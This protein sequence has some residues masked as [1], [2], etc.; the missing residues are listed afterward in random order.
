MEKKCFKGFLAFLLLAVVLSFSNVLYAQQKTIQGKITDAGNTPL[1][2]VSVS[3]KGTT[4]GTVT[5]VDGI[6]ELIVPADAANLLYSYI[7]M[8]T[9][10]I[11]I[12]TQTTINVVLQEDLV[13]LDEV[14][15][16][17]YGTRIKEEITGS[18]STVSADQLQTSAA[19]SVMNRIQGQVSGVTVTNS[20]RP[21]GDATVRIRGIGTINDSNPLYV[22]DGVPVGPGNNINPDD[23]ESISILKD[24]S[25]SAIYGTRGANGVILIT[26]KKGQLNQ[27]PTVNFSFKGGVKK[28]ANQYDMLNTTEYAD[29]L[30]LMYKNQG[31]SPAHLQFGSGSSPVIPDYIVPTAGKEGSADVNPALYDFKTYGIAKANKTGTNW[32]DE[33]YQNGI[34]QQYDLSVAGGGKNGTYSFSG[35]YLDEEGILI[36]TDFKRYNFRMNSEAKVNDWLKVGETVQAI[37]IDENGNLGNN[38][39]GTPIS[40]A[41]RAQPI[42]PVYD[43]EGNFAGSRAKEMGNAS[44]PVADLYRARNNNGKWARVIGSAYG[45]IFFMKN[46]SFKSLLGYNWG[47]WNYKGYVIPNYEHSEPNTVNGYNQDSNYSLLWN[48]TNTVNYN[49]VFN[50]IHKLNV[51]LGTEAIESN[52]QSLNASRRVYFSEDPKYMQLNSGEENKDN[53]GNQEQWSLFS[54]FGRVNYD[55]MGK[56]YLEASVRRDGSSRF[57]EANRFGTFPAASIGWAMTEEDFMDGTSNWL[58][59]LKLRL[60]YGILGNDRIGNY[61]SYTT[62]ASNKYT[63]AYALTGS[64][65][66]AVTGFQP[67]SLGNED[68]TWETTKTIDFGID[69]LLFD[70]TLNFALDIWQ[71]NTSDMLVQEPIPQVMGNAAAPFVNIGEMKNTGFDLELG[72]NN[73]AFDGQ[74]KYNVAATFSHYK[75]E[76]TSLYGDP[77]KIQDAANERQMLYS[78]YAVGT[79]FPEFWGYVVEGIFQTDAEAAAH[80][81]IAEGYNQAGHFKYKDVNGRDADGKLTGKPDGE[82][83]VDDRTWIG[84]PHP[85]FT[86]GLNIDLAWG[87]FDLNMFFYGSYGND[88]INYVTRWIDYGMFNGGLSKKALY[89]S[90]GSQYL[91]SNSDAS[92]PMF[93]YDSRSQEPSTAFVQDAS[94]LRM[95]NLQ[96]GYTLPKSLLNKAQ[97]KNLY[98]YLQVSNLFTITKYEGLDPEVNASGTY[99]GMDMGAWPTSRQVMFGVQLGL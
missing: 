65:T 17:G 89:E 97:I 58:D 96:F 63:A 69:G 46:L 8:K 52:Y 6:Y 71:R 76:I 73:T 62:F 22:I 33:I 94:Y 77:N 56:Y 4:V 54:M 80:P 85:D 48:W 61:N 18:V 93:D 50:D 70:R 31:T 3:V 21:G 24:A 47:Q 43:I 98:V 16:I 32:Y 83:N 91:A 41:Y 11:V 14:V 27:S 81:E 25:S 2:G 7:G 36:H 23:V 95:K 90:W 20:N 10:D 12:G 49:Q 64:N 74:L 28:A 78:R 59:M 40:Q 29:A 75:N 66:S 34:T 30:W 60:G 99:M 35:G 68:V 87:A 72:Y 37:F 92:L 1:P 67:A 15:V 82:L 55:L 51:V 5:D 13:G 86:G 57:S 26:T 88:M 53:S 44:N 9:Q 38:G 42:I 79:A 84:S 45:E 39:E 19:T